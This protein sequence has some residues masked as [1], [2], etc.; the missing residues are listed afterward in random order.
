MT[1]LS[2]LR[3]V[4]FLLLQRQAEFGPVVSLGEGGWALPG[5][6]EERGTSLLLACSSESTGLI[7]SPLPRISKEQSP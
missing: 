5:H 4:A 7:N 2:V 1:L 6:Q 3:V